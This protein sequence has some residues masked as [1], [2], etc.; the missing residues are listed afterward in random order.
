MV[1]LERLYN[2]VMEKPLQILEIFKDFF[3]EDRVDLQGYPDL[4]TIKQAYNHT[5]TL[6]ELRGVIQRY[7][8]FILVKFPYVKITNEYNKSTD[9]FDLFAKVNILLDGRMS[10]NFLLNRATYTTLH[11]SNN[12]MHSHVSNIPFDD[13]TQFQRPCTGTGPINSTMYTLSEGFD[14]DIWRLFCLELDKYV[15]VE[16]IAGVP[17]HRLETLSQYENRGNFSIGLRGNFPAIGHGYFTRPRVA[18]FIKCIIDKKILKFSYSLGGYSLAMPSEEAVIKISNVFIDWYNKKFNSGEFHYTKEE[19]VN[20][21]ILTKGI[22]K[23]GKI[24]TERTRQNRDFSQYIGRQVCVFKGRPVTINIT[25]ATTASDE[26][27]I[28][29]LN[30]EIITYIITTILKVLNFR[31][32]NKDNEESSTSGKTVLYL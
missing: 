10:G 4:E 26:N 13:F 3:G 2:Q 11:M 27:S 29:I 1:A 22:Y 7:S 20:E 32:G 8:G 28:Y 14:E 16:S 25:D 24:L 30:I 9:I 21:N 18:D 6:E 23:G 17:Y 12:Y 5:P 31:Y 19:L 15:H